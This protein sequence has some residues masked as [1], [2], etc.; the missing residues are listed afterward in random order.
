M[1]TRQTGPQYNQITYPPFHVTH[2]RIEFPQGRT[3]DSGTLLPD[4]GRAAPVPCRANTRNRMLN[5][6]GSAC[7]AVF[8]QAW[9]AK[10]ALPG[11]PRQLG[12]NIPS[13]SLL[14]DAPK[15]RPVAVKHGSHFMLVPRPQR[16]R[17]S[18]PTHLHVSEWRPSADVRSERQSTVYS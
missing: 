2:A 3:V 11:F 17:P 13:S 16:R 7:P 4:R 15:S 8:L 14:R 9:P 5:Q 6:P 12:E 18:Y 10:S 1:D